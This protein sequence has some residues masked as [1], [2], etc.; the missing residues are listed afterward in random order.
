MT[1]SNRSAAASPDA[2]QPSLR[3]QR[4][5]STRDQIIA[6][7]RDAFTQDGYRS[8]TISEIARRARVGRATFYMHFSGKAELADEIARSI[9]PVMARHLRSLAD[10]PP[11][12]DRIERWLTELVQLLRSLGPIPAVVNEAVGYN[13]VLARVMMDSLREIADRLADDLTRAGHLPDDP[14]R[15]QLAALLLATADLAGL[16]FGP[17]PEPSDAQNLADLAR[18]WHRVLH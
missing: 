3:D 17:E 6:A 11:T 4:K 10:E 18:L 2:A 9:N 14:D 12:L 5:Q 15:G 1:A 8:T 13:R 7:A 16:M